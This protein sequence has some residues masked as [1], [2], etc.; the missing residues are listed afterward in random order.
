MGAEQT[1]QA[2]VMS[3]GAR[4][5]AGTYAQA[6][7]DHLDDT[8]RADPATARSAVTR[9]AAD[10]LAGAAALVAEIRGAAELFSMPLSV[11]ARCDLVGRVF[12]G[13]VGEA[14]YALLGVMARRGRMALLGAVARAFAALG[15]AAHRHLPKGLVP[16]LD[17]VGLALDALQ[18]HV[19]GEVPVAGLRHL[20][21]PL[22]ESLAFALRRFLL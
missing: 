2:G 11:T 6:L 8:A 17:V 10:E 20:L 9:Q 5:L 12:D 4:A 3:P 18:V 13:R 22:E 21:G 1:T 15:L 19:D 16:A 7:L 14:T